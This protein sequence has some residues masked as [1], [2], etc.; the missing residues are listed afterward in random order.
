MP[1]FE[2]EPA[3]LTQGSAAVVD[4]FLMMYL[5]GASGC[6]LPPGTAMHWAKLLQERGMILRRIQRHVTAGFT[7]TIRTIPTAARLMPVAK[8]G[9]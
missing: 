1:A 4:H 6:L 2:Q 8:T 9:H 7:N 5:W 3:P